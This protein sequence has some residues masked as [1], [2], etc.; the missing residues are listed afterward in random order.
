MKIFLILIA[1]SLF[2]NASL[3]QSASDESQ[4]FPSIRESHIQ[5]VYNYKNIE[6]KNVDSGEILIKCSDFIQDI[7]YQDYADFCEGNQFGKIVVSWN[8]DR[9]RVWT[10]GYVFLQD[11]RG[12]AIHAILAT[13]GVKAKITFNQ[14]PGTAG[15]DYPVEILWGSYEVLLR[16]NHVG[17]GYISYIRPDGTYYGGIFQTDFYAQDVLGIHLQSESFSWE[18]FGSDRRIKWIIKGIDHSNTRRCFHGTVDFR[19]DNAPQFIK[20]FFECEI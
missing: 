10:Y 11:T 16:Y 3:A 5:V 13:N 19:P 7:K 18:Y 8:E 1:G 15:D 2:A 12:R 6:V 14:A 17:N 20:S 4:Y 9:G